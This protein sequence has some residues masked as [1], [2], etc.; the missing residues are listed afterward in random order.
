[1]TTAPLTIVRRPT[2]YVELRARSAFSFLRGATLPE[3]LAIRAGE[4]GYRAM[5]MGDYGGLYGAVR[6]YDSA[7]AAG[8][9]PLV[10]ADLELEGLG[11]V[12]LL[13]ESEA[14]YRNL[15]RLFTLAHRGQ[16]KG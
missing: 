11:E 1:M 10:A 15:C 3:D 9:R 13:V 12:R 2:P 7:K 8:I 5:A 6:F 14:G 16:P 4:L